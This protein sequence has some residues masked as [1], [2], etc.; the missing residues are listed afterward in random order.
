MLGEQQGCRIGEQ[1]ANDADD[2]KNESRALP[3]LQKISAMTEKSASEN[4][5]DV[6]HARKD[7]HTKCGKEGNEQ[8]VSKRAGNT[9]LI[10]SALQDASRST[11]EEVRYN[12]RKNKSERNET[13]VNGPSK[14]KPRILQ[15]RKT[16]AENNGICC[17]GKR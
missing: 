9:A 7:R 16:K 4:V 2:R 1:E 13:C 14:I 10:P 15:Q 8:T 11:T 12:A 5:A 6:S 17:I 3:T